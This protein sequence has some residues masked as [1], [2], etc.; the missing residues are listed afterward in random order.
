[1]ALKKIDGGTQNIQSEDLKVTSQV[2]GVIT[3][4]QSLTDQ[5]TTCKFHQMQLFKS[6]LSNY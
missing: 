4:I 5:T 6:S 2:I 3:Y 1:M